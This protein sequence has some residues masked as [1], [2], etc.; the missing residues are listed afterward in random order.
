MKVNY[1]KVNED[2]ARIHSRLN[3]LSEKYEQ[4]LDPTVI[5][6][7]GKGLPVEAK[8]FLAWRV[9][10]NPD[11]CV[12]ILARVDSF[13]YVISYYD[14]YEIPMVGRRLSISWDG[15]FVKDTGVE[16]ILGESTKDFL[17]RFLRA[18]LLKVDYLEESHESIN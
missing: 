16:Q 2:Y 5:I 12:D 7:I 18:Y 14:K 15:E 1:A 3:E 4:D 10:S 8:C 11:Y 9:M 13:E 17:Q 6:D